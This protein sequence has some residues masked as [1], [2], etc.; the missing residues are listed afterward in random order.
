MD[1][2][3]D[4]QGPGRPPSVLRAMAMWRPRFGTLGRRCGRL[5]GLM[6]G[7]RAVGKYGCGGRTICIS[8]G[9]VGRI[10]C[11]PGAHTST[12]RERTGSCGGNPSRDPVNPFSIAPRPVRYMIDR[13]VR[14]K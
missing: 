13:G 14:G 2:S 5:E 11:A 7:L 3:G 12:G 8:T 4:G 10:A 6:G 9:S 1:L